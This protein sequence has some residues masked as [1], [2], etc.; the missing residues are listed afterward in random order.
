MHQEDHPCPECRGSGAVPF[1]RLPA[2]LRVHGSTLTGQCTA[3]TAKGKRCLND[4]GYYPGGPSHMVCALHADQAGFGSEAVAGWWEGP[5]ADQPAS[6]NLGPSWVRL[7][8]LVESGIVMYALTS[9]GL[10]LSEEAAALVGHLVTDEALATAPEDVRPIA[11]RLRN[12][13]DRAAAAQK[14][15]AR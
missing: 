1:V 5:A 7:S 10:L 9:D 2:G 6:Q 4:F 11:Q 12:A 8:A 13:A 15:R 14:K 3:E